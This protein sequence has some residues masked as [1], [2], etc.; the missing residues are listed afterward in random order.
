MISRALLVGSGKDRLDVL[1]L[2][3]HQVLVRGLIQCLVVR[4]TTVSM[5]FIVALVLNPVG[6]KWVLT[7]EK[8]RVLS[9]SNT[10]SLGGM[11]EES[12]SQILSRT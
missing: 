4:R 2:L 5:S 10:A 8:P 6:E 9:S 11:G 7:A 12:R 3:S 1:L